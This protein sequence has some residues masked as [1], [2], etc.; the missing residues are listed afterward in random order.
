MDVNRRQQERSWQD[1]HPVKRNQ[2]PAS[3]AKRPAFTLIEL[4]VVI[5]II[6]ILAALLLPAL[7]KGKERAKG[8]LCMNNSRQ[9]MLGWKMYTDDYTDLLV[10][11][12]QTASVTAQGRVAAVLGDYRM[13]D[14][15]IWDPQVY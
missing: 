2:T 8:V 12:K 15:G 10:A 1:N 14:Q 13:P 3:L 4:L 11:A 5:A 9:M 6:A 7:A